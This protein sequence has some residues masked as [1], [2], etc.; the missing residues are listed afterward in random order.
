MT[1]N[2]KVIVKKNVDIKGKT[3]EKSRIKDN[4]KEL[5]SP[6]NGNDKANGCG[7]I[8]SELEIQNRNS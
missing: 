8:S 5:L 7:T 3:I 1:T 4:K 6:R 2:L